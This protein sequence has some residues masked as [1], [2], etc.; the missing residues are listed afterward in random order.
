ML[1]ETLNNKSN[2]GLVQHEIAYPLLK[3]KINC[4]QVTVKWPGTSKKGCCHEDVLV[5]I[6]FTAQAG[7][8][9]AIVG[10]VGSGKV[11]Q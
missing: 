7:Q 8:T 6:S 1:S 9:V 11:S 4:Q 5:D 2:T 3:C 10:E